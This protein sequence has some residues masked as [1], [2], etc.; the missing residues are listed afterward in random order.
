MTGLGGF[1]CN[2][3]S[4]MK[5]PLL[6]LAL[7]LAAPSARA[8]SE[9]VALDTSTREI[10]IAP[11]FDG[12]EITVFG[13][14]DN[15]RQATKTAGYYDIIVVVRGPAE[16]IVARRKDPVFGIWV[17]RG[18]REFDRVPS[19]YGILSNRPIG[20]IADQETL[21]RFDIEF[22]A[23]PLDAMRVP[24]DVYETA[25]LRLKQKQGMYVKEPDSVV[26][27]SRSLFRATLHFPVQVLEGTYTAQIYLFHAGK[28]LSWD[29]SLLEVR[30]TG[31]ERWLHTMASNQP[32]TYGILSVAVAVLAGFLGWSLFRR[33]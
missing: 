28:L 25:L 29:T 16:T 12:A 19:F 11:D 21:N 15:S 14:V 7:L 10:S 30:K 32:W 23:T 31:I 2:S 1:A 8:Q 22:D 33:S 17:N 9:A 4:L 24:P 26:F 20:E 13:A 6:V 5:A 3:G 27:L 18:A